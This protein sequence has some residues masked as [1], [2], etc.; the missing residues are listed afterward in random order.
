MLLMSLHDINLAARFCNRVVMLFGE[1]EAAQGTA[2]E[3]LTPEKLSRLYRVPVRMLPWE[4]GRAF[5]AG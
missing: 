3:M 1:G 2:D 4:G 5:L